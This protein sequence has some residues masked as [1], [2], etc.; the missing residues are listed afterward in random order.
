MLTAVTA[1]AS[2]TTA[3]VTPLSGRPVMIVSPRWVPQLAD[4]DALVAV[5]VDRNRSVDAPP[6]LVSPARK[7]ATSPGA[8]GGG[9]PGATSGPLQALNI[10]RLASP[11]SVLGNPIPA[12]PAVA[13]LLWL[14]SN[15]SD[16]VTGKRF[17]GIKWDPA[18]PPAQ[19]AL[20]AAAC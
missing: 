1:A 3:A 16:G 15:A 19:A 2:W 17:L 12:P 13:P 14:C 9:A 7:T 6:R 10:M 4:A 18:L 11:Q 20:A 5:F 8:S